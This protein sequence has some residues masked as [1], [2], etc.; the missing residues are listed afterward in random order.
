[1]AVDLDP[2]R[3]A[4][5]DSRNRDNPARKLDENT[6]NRPKTMPACLNAAGKASSPVPRMVF[7][8][9]RMDDFRLAPLGFDALALLIATMSRSD[10]FSECTGDCRATAVGSYGKEVERRAL[11]LS[12]RRRDT[13][14]HQREQQHRARA[15]AARGLL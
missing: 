5:S 3:P 6:I 4:A 15:Q 2:D 10:I 12:V 14:H 8:K 9:L 13:V 7:D 1:M 11:G